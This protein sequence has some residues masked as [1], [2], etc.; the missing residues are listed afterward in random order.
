MFVT[1]CYQPTGRTDSAREIHTVLAADARRRRPT[2]GRNYSPRGLAS[3]TSTTQLLTL[4]SPNRTDADGRRAQLVGGE[5][6]PRRPGGHSRERRDARAA[7]SGS[8]EPGDVAHCA[9]VAA[10]EK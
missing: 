10:H 5:N 2:H 3:G 4:P 1:S 7:C 6:L 8:V 9:M